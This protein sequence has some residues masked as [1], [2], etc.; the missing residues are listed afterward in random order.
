MISRILSAPGPELFTSTDKPSH[1]PRCS[2]GPTDHPPILPRPCSRAVLEFSPYADEHMPTTLDHE[3]V[4][5]ETSSQNPASPSSA[6]KTCLVKRISLI[7]HFVLFPAER[8]G[9]LP[10]TESGNSCCAGLRE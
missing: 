6:A 10:R 2:L 8:Q 9:I 4:R 5:Q 1:L 3:A 7:S